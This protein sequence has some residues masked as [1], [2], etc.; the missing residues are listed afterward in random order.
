M[1]N[2]IKSI[3]DNQQSIIDAIIQ[4]HC[5]DGIDVDM[6]YGNGCFYKEIKQPKRMFDIDPQRGGVEK[7][8]SEMLP[9]E[10]ESINS[11]MFDPPFLTYVRQER[12]GNGNMIMAKRFSGYWTYGELEDHYI[13]SISEA[14]RILQYGGKFIIKCQDIIHNHRLH[15]THHN[16]ILWADV[17]GFRLVDLFILEAKHRLPAPNKKGEQKHARIYHSY[18]LVFEKVK[19]NLK[20]IKMSQR[21]SA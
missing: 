18:F 12:N 5:K 17:E 15:C 11:C 16:V 13:H 7:A 20:R 14:Y 6:T 3:Y 19:S 9:V 2:I 8:S 4:L 1:K 21:E 10:K